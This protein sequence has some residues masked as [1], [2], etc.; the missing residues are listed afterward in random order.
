[1]HWLT[2]NKRVAYQLCNVENT[3]VIDRKNY[4]Q[5]N[6]RTTEVNILNAIFIVGHFSWIKLVTDEEI[7]GLQSN[8]AD[9]D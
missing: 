4:L 8:K 6:C 2:V 7:S 3:T 9:Q 5:N 1:M